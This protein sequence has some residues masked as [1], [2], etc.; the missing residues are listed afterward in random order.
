MTSEMKNSR[1]IGTAMKVIVNGSADGVAT[2]AKTKMPTMIH[3]RCAPR[4]LPDTTPA[5]LS[6]T[7]KTGISKARPKT[8][9]VRVKN[10]RYS[11]K[12]T[13]LVTPS[14]LSPISTSRPLGSVT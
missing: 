5:R 6:I 3:G 8:S 2:A 12:S 7:T 1:T 11:L 13:R 9:R 4:L 10:W 14:G